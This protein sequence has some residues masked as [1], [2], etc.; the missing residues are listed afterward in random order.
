MM[1]LVVVLGFIFILTYLNKV[2]KEYKP[3]E[4]NVSSST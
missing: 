1:A 2:E 4:S 3:V